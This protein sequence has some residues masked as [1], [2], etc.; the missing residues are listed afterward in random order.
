MLLAAL[1]CEGHALLIGVP[2]L[3]KTRLAR[4]LAAALGWRFARIQFTPDLMPA[5]IIGTEVLHDV[6]GEG[7]SMRFV[8]GPLFANFVLADEINRTPPKTQAALLEAMQERQVTSLGETR[9]L[10]R[11]F[12]VVATQNPIEFEGTYPLPEAQLDRFMLSLWMDYPSRDDER[13]IVAETTV[14]PDVEVAPVLEP[15]RFAELA[16]LVRQLPAAPHVI[17]YAV[18][19]VRST[20]PGREE[21]HAWADRYLEWG[22]GPRAGQHL[23]SLGKALALLDGRPAVSCADIREAAPHVLRHRVLP[24]DEAAADGIDARVILDRVIADVAEPSYDPAG[25]PP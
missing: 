25:N 15:S 7:R 20:R 5:D 12:A 6:P 23:V 21:A 4:T 18:A 22:A 19:L 13:Q 9:P 16:D 14:T 8:P 11:P 10:P 2:G 1:L 17:D 24:H 3:A